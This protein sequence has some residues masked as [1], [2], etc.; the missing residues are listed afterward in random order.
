MEKNQ[1]STDQKNS[2]I[3]KTGYGNV[4]SP[5][6]NPEKNSKNDDLANSSQQ[7]F[8]SDKPT[9]DERSNRDRTGKYDEADPIWPLL[10]STPRAGPATATRRCPT[11]AGAFSWPTRSRVAKLVLAITKVK[12]SGKK[13]QA[14]TV[15]LFA[16]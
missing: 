10:A 16:A 15:A 4:G 8:G 14:N 12:T 5:E 7:Q 6:K 9:P 1:T 13:C 3:Q 2:G 11:T